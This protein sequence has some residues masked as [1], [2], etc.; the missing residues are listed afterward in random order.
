VARSGAGSAVLC[1]QV[2]ETINACPAPCGVT[3]H[4]AKSVLSPR[5]RGTD[6]GSTPD[7]NDLL[8]YL[9]TNPGSSSESLTKQFSTDAGTLRPVMRKLID[10]GKVKTQG[11]RRGMRY[12]ASV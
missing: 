5:P 4:S 6:N 8:S 9:A 10:D 3:T 12:Y 11:Q 1:V 2:R 7:A